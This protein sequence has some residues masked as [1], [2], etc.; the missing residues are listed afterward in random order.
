MIYWQDFLL[1][2]TTGPVLIAAETMREETF[3]FVRRAKRNN[4][5]MGK[6]ELRDEMTV[7]LTIQEMRQEKWP[8]RMVG[9][10]SLEFQSTET[11]PCSMEAAGPCRE[12]K[13]GEKAGEG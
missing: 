10:S 9:S 7:S 8:A 4:N 3:R 11:K 6:P 5:P 13:E 12:L 1:D 2:F